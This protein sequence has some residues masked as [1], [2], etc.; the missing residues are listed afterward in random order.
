MRL[1]PLLLSMAMLV[2]LA[3]PSS[4]LHAQNSAS[5]CAGIVSDAERLACYDRAQRGAP[6][7]VSSPQTGAAESPP[8]ATTSGSANATSAQ[9]AAPAT[10]AAP[11]APAIGTNA[12]PATASA[13]PATST[14]AAPAIVP[15]VVVATRTLPGRPTEFTTET[16]QVWV[17]TDA[18]RASVPATPFN[19]EIRPGVIGSTFLVPADRRAIRVRL[20]Q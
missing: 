15:I 12:A 3:L 1:G 8:P 14:N 13:A 6:A 11:T 19:A 4:K 5:A 7:G 2:V 18:Q 17:Q 10:A 9:A 20:R 16:G